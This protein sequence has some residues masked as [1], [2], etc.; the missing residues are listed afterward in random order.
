[1]GR[2]LGSNISF[3]TIGNPQTSLDEGKY[4]QKSKKMFIRIQLFAINKQKQA[5]HNENN[6]T[7]RSVLYGG[8]KAAQEII[9]KYSGKGIKLPHGKERVE[10]DHIIGIYVSKERNTKVESKV[11]II[12]HSKTG[13]HVY[14][15]N[16]NIGG[17]E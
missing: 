4:E 2:L 7:G 5:R 1:M 14:P 12:V 8:E 11:A 3:G 9:D 15:G 16:P 17:K 13:D 6:K 10:T